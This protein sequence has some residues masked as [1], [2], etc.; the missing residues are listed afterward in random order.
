[1]KA[2]IFDMDGVI[3]DS[4]PLHNKIVRSILAENNISLLMKNSI[5]SLVWLLLLYL[6]FS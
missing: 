3:I 4:E 2:F 5:N 6:I 1:M